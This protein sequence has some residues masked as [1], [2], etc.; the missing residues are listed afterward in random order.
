MCRLDPAG[1]ELRA[2]S[3]ENGGRPGLDQGRLRRVHDVAV[4]DGGRLVER[5]PR[6]T[7]A[8]DP[9]SRLSALLRAG[10]AGRSAEKE[11]LA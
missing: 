3:L 5:G 6:R 2:N 10:A 4:L 1:R 7:L 8:A 9:S 11:L